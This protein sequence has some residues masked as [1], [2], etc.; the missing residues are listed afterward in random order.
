MDG[1]QVKFIIYG[2]EQVSVTSGAVILFE[3]EVVTFWEWEIAYRQELLKDVL[4][5]GRGLW[6]LRYR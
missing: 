3:W 4:I 2:V 1:E 5:I 6:Y